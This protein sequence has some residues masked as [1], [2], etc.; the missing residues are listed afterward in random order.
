MKHGYVPLWVLVNV[1]S[2][3]NISKFYEHR[4]QPLRV[5]IAKHFNVNVGDLCLYI[6]MLAFWRNFCAHDERLYDS[7]SF[8]KNK[9]A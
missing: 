6:K 5:K 8:K 9:L 4:K 1:L 7:T 3:G 2:L